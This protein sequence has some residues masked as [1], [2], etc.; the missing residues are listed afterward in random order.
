MRKNYSKEFFEQL[1]DN[2]RLTTVEIDYRMPD[3]LSILQEFMWQ[4]M[5][6]PPEYPR[7]H[8]FIDYWEINIEAPIYSVTIANKPVI[9][10]SDIKT[11]DKYFKI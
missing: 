6:K 5:D 9:T 1:N 8:V 11:I 10:P 7:I 3:Y 2:F 4:T